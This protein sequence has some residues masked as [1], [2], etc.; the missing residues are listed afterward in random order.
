MPGDLILL[1][2]HVYHKCKSYDIWFRKYKVQ[3]TE[4]FVILGHFLS[5][6]PPNNLENQ[7]FKIEKN[8]WR[9]YQK[10][11]VQ[12]IMT[13]CYTVPQIWHVMDFNCY[14]SF[15]ATVYKNHD[16]MLYTGPEIWCVMDVIIFH[17]GPFFAL[18]PL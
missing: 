16:H 5:F 15:W 8:T 18:L 10:S 12:N 7:H 4:M 9:Y 14:F 3:Q 13:I 2:I 17:C 11:C 1:Q 6:Q